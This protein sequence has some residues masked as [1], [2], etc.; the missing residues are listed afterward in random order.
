MKPSV[1]L[2]SDSQHTVSRTGDNFLKIFLNSSELRVIEM[3]EKKLQALYAEHGLF[4]NRPEH[5]RAFL[6]NL[7]NPDF[8]KMI[9]PEL[10]MKIEV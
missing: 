3:E 5:F 4:Y 10:K 8:V 9:I 1:L 2:S 7:S 6:L